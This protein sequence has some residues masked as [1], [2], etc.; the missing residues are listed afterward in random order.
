M[1]IF[2]ILADLVINSANDVLSGNQ[3]WEEHNQFLKQA[4]AEYEL[5][6]VKLPLDLSD[7]RNTNHENYRRPAFP[8][9]GA[10]ARP[11]ANEALS[12]NDTSVRARSLFDRC[13]PQ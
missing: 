11:K 7:E 3:T 2:N 12:D 10:V 6:D 1:N 13:E 9:T 4:A 5:Q 8:P